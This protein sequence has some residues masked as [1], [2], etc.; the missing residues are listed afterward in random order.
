MKITLFQVTKEFQNTTLEK[1]LVAILQS[2]SRSY[3]SKLIKNGKVKINGEINI[4]RLAKVKTGDKVEVEFVDNVAESIISQDIPFQI[5]FEN[6][7]LIVINKESGVVVH[8]GAG[9]VD[10]TLLNAVKFYLGENSQPVMV[11]RIDKETSGIVLVAKNPKARETYAKEFEMRNAK[12][13]YICVVRSEIKKIIQH[14]IISEIE[15]DIVSNESVE[16]ISSNNKFQ[17]SGMIGRNIRNRKIQ[18][19]FDCKVGKIKNFDLRELSIKTIG[20]RRF[21]V[22]NFEVYQEGSLDKSETVELSVSQDSISNFPYLTLLAFP[23]TGRTHQI[24]A[25]LKTVGFP[26]LGDIDYNGEKFARLMLH[27]YK[28]ELKVGN[29]L[30]EF[31]AD[32]PEEFEIFT[33]KT[34]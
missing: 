33:N 13:T 31:V 6:D 9:K 2:Y 7:D 25:H 4:S 5:I 17:I 1:F 11:N 20:D 32:I 10:G 24:R 14:E 30:K 19:I 26:I 18:Q 8:P 15:D 12:K 21:A 3:L 16:V 34:S 28:L 23:I 22:T 29:E 27:S